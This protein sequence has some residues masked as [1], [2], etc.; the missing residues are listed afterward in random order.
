MTPVTFALL[1]GVTGLLFLMHGAQKLLGA[2]GGVDGAGASVPLATQIGVAGG[3]ELVGGAL[4]LI[5]LFTRPVAFL[6]AGEMAVAYFQVHFPN[7]FWPI[8]NHGELAVL[9]CFIFL[10]IA[11]HGA[12]A[13]SVDAVINQRRRTA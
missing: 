4:I 1:R 11:A 3:L 9:Y 7:A 12:G 2:F 6:L 5:G 13:Y 8:E 10:F